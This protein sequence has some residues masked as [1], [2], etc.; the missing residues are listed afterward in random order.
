[1]GEL[2]NSMG[3]KEV[4]AAVRVK[5]AADE[6]IEKGEQLLQSFLWSELDVCSV[7]PSFSHLSKIAQGTTALNRM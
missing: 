1:M 4:F 7:R 6:Q 5:P 2:Y 3:S